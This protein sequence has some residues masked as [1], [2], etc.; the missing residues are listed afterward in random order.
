MSRKCIVAMALT[1]IMLIAMVTPVAAAN[2]GTGGNNK[3]AATPFPE[4]I[5]LAGLLGTEDKTAVLPQ[6]FVGLYEQKIAVGDTTRTVKAYIPETAKQGCNSLY[7]AVPE[8]VDTIKFMEDSGWMK[9]AKEHNFILFAFEPVNEVWMESDL[10]YI[11]KAFAQINNR[12]YYNFIMGNYYFVGY[13]D[14][15]TLLQKYIMKNPKLAAGMA[16]FNGSENISKEYMDQVGSEPS[17]D[18]N[19]PK[20][21][22]AAPVWIISHKITPNTQKVINY[23]FNANDCEETAYKFDDGTMYKQTQVGSKSDLNEQPVAK[24]QVTEKAISYTNEKFNT[25]VWEDFLSTT[26]RFGSNIYNNALRATA[27]FD[28]LGIEEH[29]MS[30]DGY[31]RQWYEYVPTYA[32]GK[33]VKLPL[34]V[35]LHGSGQTGE[36]FVGYTEWYKV[37][38]ER[39]FIVI[40]PTAAM[41]ASSGGGVQGAPRPTFN[42]DGSSSV[43]DI[44]FVDELVKNVKARN[45]VDNTR[46]YISGQSAGSMMTQRIALYLPKV[47]A[48]AGS[49][50]GSIMGISGENYQFP[51]DMNEKYQMPVRLFMGQYDL[52]GGGSLVKNTDA[53]ATLAYWIKRNN[54]GDG[55]K[56]LTYKKGLYTNL[57]YVNDKHIPM[58]EYTITANRGHNCVPQ[59][60]WELWDEWFCKY[61][62]TEDG[63][64]RYMG[65]KVN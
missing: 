58:V 33:G 65:Q 17:D 34:V 53:K 63:M 38:E 26:S 64:V 14:G 59:E 31:T 21:E 61:S 12:L 47:F 56:P 49:T 44:K 22:V 13:S 39:G 27:D 5:D 10:E 35:A 24:L 60:M 55:E 42:F 43:D 23:W 15:G 57:V 54:A 7:L 9:I 3:L 45:N 36:I 62:R 25:K 6:Y 4:N 18:P 51:S 30:L 16:I 32:R 46:V 19:L 20:S 52:F 28:A 11:Q 2:L 48:A 40:F 50:S 37:A 41:S 8:G 29:T 1:A